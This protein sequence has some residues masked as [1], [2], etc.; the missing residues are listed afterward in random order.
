LTYVA[1]RVFLTVVVV[2]EK[3]YAVRVGVGAVTVAV[4]TP[5]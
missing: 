2:M 4:K 3:V 1:T 5:V